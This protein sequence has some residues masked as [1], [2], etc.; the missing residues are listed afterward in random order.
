MYGGRKKNPAID[1]KWSTGSLTIARTGPQP[2]RSKTVDSVS[3]N[4]RA[5]EWLHGP[6][7][8]SSCTPFLFTQSAHTPTSAR[9]RALQHSKNMATVVEPTLCS[10]RNAGHTAAADP[11][12]TN[13]NRKERTSRD[14]FISRPTTIGKNAPSSLCVPEQRCSRA[15]VQTRLGPVTDQANYWAE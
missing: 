2:H 3:E 1:R 8:P 7:M 6:L 11:T 15:R 12:P 5:A 14:P 4:A 9:C 13:S 10:F